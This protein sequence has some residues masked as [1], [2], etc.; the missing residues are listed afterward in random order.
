MRA[1]AKLAVELEAQNMSFEMN[2]LDEKLRMLLA[3]YA[4]YGPWCASA[5]Q[6]SLQ[7]ETGATVHQISTW[8][9]EQEQR[10]V[11]E[12]MNVGVSDNSV[13][14]TQAWWR[15]TDLALREVSDDKYLDRSV[16]AYNS[17]PRGFIEPI[18]RNTI[19]RTILKHVV[20]KYD[21]C[22]TCER[23]LIRF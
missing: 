18:G 19:E 22:R 7:L 3:W 13:P 12:C 2:R 4:R 8:L 20:T 6:S 17:L 16:T 5:T 11:V 21:F 9:N 1:E 15:L 23:C 14:R 10:G